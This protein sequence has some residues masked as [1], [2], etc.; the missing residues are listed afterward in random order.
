[1]PVSYPHSLPSLVGCLLIISIGF[2]VACSP[3]APSP[4][5]VRSP[6]TVPATPANSEPTERTPVQTL[7]ISNVDGPHS[8]GPTTSPNA[9]HTETLPGP[10]ADTTVIDSGPTPQPTPTPAT[11]KFPGGGPLDV[12]LIE[13]WI[14]LYI[15]EVR[16]AQGLGLLMHDP[17]I[18]EVARGHSAAMAA[19]GNFSTQLGRA[20]PNDSALATGYD[21]RADLGDGRYSQGS[22][23]KIAKHPRVQRWIG[24]TR[25]GITLWQPETYDEDAREAATRIVDNW[26]ISER[27]EEVILLEKYRW[28]GVGVSVSEE[29]TN[30]WDLEIFYA[31]VNFSACR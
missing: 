15:N 26:V 22:A 12:A 23:E 21:C 24:V 13:E 9:P 4:T 3:P 25:S 20:E 30:G 28:V 2:I 19:T 29:E 17:A 8:V 31:T 27:P 14:I 18:S 1:M 16:E 6:T 5:S 7:A 11:G 10:A